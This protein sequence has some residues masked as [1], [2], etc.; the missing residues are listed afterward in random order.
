MKGRVSKKL[1]AEKIE[2]EGAPKME[3]LALPRSGCCAALALPGFCCFLPACARPA[4]APL[5]AAFFDLTLRGAK[6]SSSSSSSSSSSPTS[7]IASSSSSSTTAA[8]SSSS[9]SSSIF[10]RP[11]DL[12]FCF[13]PFFAD[14]GGGGAAMFR[15]TVCLEARED[16][17]IVDMAG[18][19]IT[20]ILLS[21]EFD[22]ARGLSEGF[23]AKSA[24]ISEGHKL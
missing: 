23:N 10:I 2:K 9:S 3:F 20:P 18:V 5:F 17:R 19:L 13:A 21:L 11:W 14:N 12:A 24:L 4:P 1:G 22:F 7:S 6:T 8:P 16:F 15:S